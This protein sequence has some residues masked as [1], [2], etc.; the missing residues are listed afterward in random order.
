M[1]SSPEK[2]IAGASGWE[3]QD[4]AESYTPRRPGVKFVLPGSKNSAG[5]RGPCSGTR[6]DPSVLA[7][8]VRLELGI[9]NP[10]PTA[11]RVA[12]RWE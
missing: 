6:G 2:T 8:H 5:T 4:G 10:W 1:L 9:P 3:T 11:L 7:R 12:G